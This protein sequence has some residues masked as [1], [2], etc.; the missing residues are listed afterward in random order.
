V[1]TLSASATATLGNATVTI[2]GNNPSVGT[3]STTV[4]L[5]VTAPP[6]GSVTVTPVLASNNPWF[7]EEQIRIANTAPITALSITIT[8][9]RNP[10]ALAIGG[11]YNSVGSTIQQ[12]SSTTATQLTYQFTLAAGQ[13]LGPSTSR[14]FAAQ[15]RG[16]GTPHPTSGDTYSVTYT[17][18]GATSTVSGTF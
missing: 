14:T 15:I 9:Q 11:Q 17:S 16:N 5:S 10:A 3:R 6:S 1:L 12:S 4:A 8:V 18:G 7:M 13:T 2:N